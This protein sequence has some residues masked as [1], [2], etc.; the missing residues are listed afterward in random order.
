MI[1]WTPW[2]DRPALARGLGTAVLLGAPFLW[3]G[4]LLGGE[5]F[6]PAAALGH[7][8]AM[9]HAMALE[10][11]QTGATADAFHPPGYA[12]FV[13]LI[14]GLFG[15]EPGW[16]RLVQ[17]ALLPVPVACAARIGRV[18]GGRGVALGAAG[19]MALHPAAARYATNL[20][21]DLLC[22]VGV[23]MV[24]AGL[25]PVLVGRKGSSWVAAVGL[26]LALWVRPGWALLGPLL[27]LAV[28]ATG[29]TRLAGRTLWPV[30]LV[31]GL[32]LAANL[33][34]FPP[35]PGAPVRG[36]HTASASLLLG[37]WQFEDRL[38]DWD[39]LEPGEP[40]YDRF[41]AQE[42]EVIASVPGKG[43]PHPDVKAAIRS[44]AWQRYRH[45]PRLFKK[46]G[47]SAVRLWVLFP[48][49][50][51]PP[52]RWAFVLLDV[53][54][55]LLALVGLRA[56]GRRVWLVAPFVVTPLLLHGLMH[57]E[58]RY[59]VPARAVWFACAAVGVASLA[60]RWSRRSR[61]G[62]EAS[63]RSS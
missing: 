40:N 38:W 33:A 9:Y 55:L 2:K 3:F 49:G 43:R 28:L 51:S 22:I 23:S 15:A 27:V 42:D 14:Y 48:T 12:A 58:P 5:L 63:P 19:A 18:L 21:S 39:F 47:I 46:L 13:A 37:T 17:A 50:A 62:S 52:V 10:I 31:S 41:R 32:A 36:A 30:A 1:N 7:S 11:L 53:A 59:A 26:A 45:P 34:W 61:P 60:H 54:A 4:L 8:E 35:E 44:A 20:Y 25:I 24:A 29:G 6:A 56:L 57:V 16:V